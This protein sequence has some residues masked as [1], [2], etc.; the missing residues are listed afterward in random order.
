MKQKA[1]TLIELL[2]VV[3]I[4]GILAAVGVVAYNGY[5][6]AAKI[7]ATLHHHSTIR[8]SI[9]SILGLCDVGD[10][11]SYVNKN[12]YT[13]NIPCDDSLRMYSP[14]LNKHGGFRQ[15]GKWSYGFQ[16]PYNYDLVGIKESPMLSYSGAKDYNKKYK[17]LQRNGKLS[18]GYICCITLGVVIVE[19][20]SVNLAN[21]GEFNCKGSCCFYITTAYDVDEND[22]AKVK[23]DVVS[24]D[25][26]TK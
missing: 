16:N 19:R 26:C 8:N 24:G 7:K 12:G 10:P 23:I 2:V 3:A 15:G 11:V 21:A 18:S 17:P 4:I 13:V 20:A 5:T 22:N 6:K 9:Q 14:I 25:S 1:F